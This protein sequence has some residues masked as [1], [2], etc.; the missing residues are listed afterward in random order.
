MHSLLQRQLKRH[1]GKAFG[2][3]GAVPPEWEA[4]LHVVNEAYEQADADRA[5]LERSLELTSQELIERNKAVEAK[6]KQVELLNRTM[7]GREERILELKEEIK[8]LRGRMS[9]QTSDEPHAS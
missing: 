5:L 6:L 3:Q 4:F 8:K 2:V 1:L 7:M 9:P